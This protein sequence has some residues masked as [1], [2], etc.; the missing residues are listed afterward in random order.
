MDAESEGSCCPQLASSVYRRGPT[1]TNSAMFP[2]ERKVAAAIE[3][4]C[5][6][7]TDDLPEPS[8]N[9]NARF[10]GPGQV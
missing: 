3:A 4:R 2:M 5:G 9:S 1:D 10:G 8:P 6:K 7:A